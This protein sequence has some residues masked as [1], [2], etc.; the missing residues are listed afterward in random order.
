MFELLGTPPDQKK[1]Y[2][3]EA[4]HHVP[5]NILLRETLN[6]LDTYLGPTK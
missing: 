6:W 2:V 5:Q 1:Q 3:Y 4:G